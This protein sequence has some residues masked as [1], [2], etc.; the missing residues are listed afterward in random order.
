[1]SLVLVV[2][3][4]AINAVVGTLGAIA[5]VRH[6]IGRHLVSALCIRSHFSGDDRPGVSLLVGGTVFLV[7]SRRDRL[8]VVFSFPAS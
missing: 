3:A 8:K 1:M 2:I 5:I 7:R 4:L 6:P